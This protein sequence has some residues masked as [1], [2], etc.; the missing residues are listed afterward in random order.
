MSQVTDHADFRANTRG[1]AKGDAEGLL[2]WLWEKGRVATDKD[3]QAFMTCKL[4]NRQYRVAIHK[5]QAFM[6][7]RDV[8]TGN[9]VTLIKKR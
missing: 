6:V 4:D 9:F 1:K 8:T 5:G 7:V 2:R 3:F